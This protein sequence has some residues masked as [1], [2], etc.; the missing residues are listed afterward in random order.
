MTTATRRVSGSAIVAD[1]EELA[2]AGAIDDIAVQMVRQGLFAI[3]DLVRELPPRA[4]VGSGDACRS[5]EAVLDL[6][7]PGRDP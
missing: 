3:A 7:E 2:V 5:L 1:L 6:V 4:A